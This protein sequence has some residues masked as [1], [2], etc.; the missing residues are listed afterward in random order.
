MGF[1]KVMRA[2]SLNDDEEFT[3]GLAEVVEGSILRGEYESKNRRIKCFKCP[4]DIC[5]KLCS[6]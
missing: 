5:N 1:E 6:K 3:D 2:A 4:F